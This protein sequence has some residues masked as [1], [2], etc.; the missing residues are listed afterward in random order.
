MKTDTL[1][2]LLVRRICI[3]FG[4]GLCHIFARGQCKQLLFSVVDS[5]IYRAVPARRS[6]DTCI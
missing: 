6:V 1:L 5:C 4:I 3:G 2:V